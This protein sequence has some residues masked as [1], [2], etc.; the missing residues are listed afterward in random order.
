MNYFSKILPSGQLLNR[1]EGRILQ[2]SGRLPDGQNTYIMT[3]KSYPDGPGVYADILLDTWFKRAF[4]EY[5]NAKRLMLLFLQ[6]LIPERKIVSIEYASEESTNQQPD[7]KNIRVD[8]E[9]CDDNGRRFV[10]EVQQC[11]QHDFYDRAVFNS[12]FAVQRQLQGGTGRYGFPA[13]YFIGIIRF[14]L[15]GESERFLYRYSLK[16]DQTGELMTDSLHYIFLEV[17]KCRLTPESSPV[18]KLGYALDKLQFMDKKPDNLDGEFFDLLFTSADLRN[19]AP[20]EKSKYLSDMTTERDIR[21][22]IDYAREEAVAKRNREIARA[23]REK[24]YAPA[25]IQELTG[26]SPEEIEALK[27]Q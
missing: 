16:D 8:V 12:T 5:G 14:S 6:A 7:G 21:N 25:V 19:F 18:E 11:R 3:K 27:E 22:Q 20:E 23:M 10:V 9:C 24:G 1:S 17:P 2:G 15:H 13:V 26:L 4:K